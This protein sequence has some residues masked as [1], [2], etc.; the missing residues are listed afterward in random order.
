MKHL[1]FSRVWLLLALVLGFTACKKDDNP[2]TPEAAYGTGIFVVNEGLFNGGTGAISFID[3]KTS[4]VTQN[5]FELVNGRPLGNVGQSMS[6]FGQTGLLV[7]NNAN[8][9]EFV[10]LRDFRSVGVIENLALPSQIVVAGNTGKAY[11]TEWVGFGDVGRVSVIDI[12]SRSVIKTIPVGKFPNAIAFHNNRIYVANSNENTVTEI[13]TVG[14]SVLRTITV[15]D[16]P[17]SFAASQNNLLVLCGGNPSWTGTETAGSLAVISNTGTTIRN[18]PNATDHPTHLSL[19]LSSGQLLYQ[20][21][22]AVYQLDATGSGNINPGSPVINR[23][24]YYFTAD[25]VNNGLLYGTDAGD[26]QSNGKVIRYATNFVVQDSITVGLIPG[27][28]H[29]R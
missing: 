3:R 9:I 12:G 26:F 6:S 2:P 13:T 20:V 18:F 29:F 24:F 22:G 7:V 1:L 23:S 10:D 19:V 16:R 27:F 14:D 8:K 17:N 25:P 15:G 11:V 4:A 5:L 21:R 28:I